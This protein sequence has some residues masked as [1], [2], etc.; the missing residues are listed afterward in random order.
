MEGP[1]YHTFCLTTEMCKWTFKQPAL[2]QNERL[3]V[4]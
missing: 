4:A 1:F 2:K 3:Q